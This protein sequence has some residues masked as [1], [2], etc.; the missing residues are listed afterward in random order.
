MVSGIG[1]IALG[2]MPVQTGDEV[3]LMTPRLG[4]NTGRCLQMK[5]RRL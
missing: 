2:L 1:R 4:R 5:H 3:Q